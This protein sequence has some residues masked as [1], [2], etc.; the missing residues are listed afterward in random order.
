MV[1]HFTKERS[2]MDEKTEGDIVSKLRAS[3]ARAIF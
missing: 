1:D 2:I 3:R